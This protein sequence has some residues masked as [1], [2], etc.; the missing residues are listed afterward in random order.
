MKA[1]TIGLLIFFLSAIILFVLFQVGEMVNGESFRHAQTC[2][3][4]GL[5]G[6]FIF[7]YITEKQK[8]PHSIS[9]VIDYFEW[10]GSKEVFARMDG[11]G[12]L[13]LWNVNPT[14][15]TITGI[16][17]GK[18]GV[19]GGQKWSKDVQLVMDIS[20]NV[21][22]KLSYKDALLPESKNIGSVS[23]NY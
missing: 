6:A 5:Q 11:W 10:E 17:L 18:D 16:S 19:P 21:F 20:T 15:Q 22:G 14:N 1:R 2:D 7:K 13:I 12:R 4:I 8:A 3:R 23:P 9:E